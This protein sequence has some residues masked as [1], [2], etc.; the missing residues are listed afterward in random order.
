MS[1]STAV[2]Q[3]VLNELPLDH[4]H[5]PSLSSPVGRSGELDL[6]FRHPAV[7]LERG[8]R[9]QDRPPRPQEREQLAKVGGRWSGN[10][11][12]SQRHAR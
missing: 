12:L 11:E 5:A 10:C 7:M 2:I 6:D 8:E 4:G 1:L 3:R 9:E